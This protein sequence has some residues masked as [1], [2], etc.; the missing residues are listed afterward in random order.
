MTCKSKFSQKFSFRILLLFTLFF[1]SLTADDEIL[2]S[3]ILYLLKTGKESTAFS[4]YDDYYKEKG[5]HDGELLEQIGLILIENGYRSDK[6]ENKLL[7]IFGAGISM[8]EKMLT[9]LKEALSSDNPQIQLVALNFLARFHHDEG[10]QSLNQ[11]MNSNF[12]PIR[13]EAG[14][15]LAEQK[16]P[17]VAPQI[18]ALMVKVDPELTPLFPQLFGLIGTEEAI[19]ILK[20]L[21]NHPNERVRAAA[22]ISAAENERDD[23]LPTIRILASHANII[24]QEAACYAFG[25][26]KD[27]S[28]IPRLEV[29][30]LSNAPN[31]R[32][33]SLFAL[34]RLGQKTR[35]KE[36]EAMAKE[37]DLSAIFLLSE[38]EESLPLLIQLSHHEQLNVRLNASYALLQLRNGQAVSGLTEV[39]VRD[40]RDLAVLDSASVGSTLKCLKATPSAFQNFKDNAAM[41]EVSLKLKELL[42]QEAIHLPEKEFLILAKTL[43]D[44]NQNELIPLLVLL[45]EDL[46]TKEAIE[47]LLQYSQKAGAPLIRNYC[48]LALFRLKEEGPFRENLNKFILQQCQNDL[49]NFRPLLPF[50]MRRQNTLY[51]LT[52]EDSSKLLIEAF[53]AI[54]LRQ[55]EA[56]INLLLYAIRYGNIRNRYALAG[57]LMHAAR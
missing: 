2:R 5:S 28:S 40:G 12:L 16:A 57:L 15:H 24:E 17:K 46:K 22:I 33:S 42:L 1:A 43:F 26:L 8:N 41:H 25:L 53:E 3:R 23:L 31:V 35:Q 55:D 37:L 51:Q 13:L 52:P 30:A 18:E 47:L 50:A 4:L 14:L 36:I 20:R 7:A 29:L 44:T 19:K 39:L 11:A 38:M 34:Y 49:I 27:E 54:T 45:L 21:L 10:D 56:G 48:N 6:S 32:L 9:I